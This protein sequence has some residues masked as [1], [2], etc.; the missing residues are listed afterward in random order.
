MEI[1]YIKKNKKNKK[2]KKKKG[3]KEKRLESIKRQFKRFNKPNK[4]AAVKNMLKE[5]KGDLV[6]LQET[7]IDKM[8]RYIVR[9]LWGILL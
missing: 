6:C 8:E 7:K 4:R 2:N 9:S 1:I 5:W 3:K